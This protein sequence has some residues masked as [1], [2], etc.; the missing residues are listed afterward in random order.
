MSE[1]DINVQPAEQEVSKATKEENFTA[2]EILE[3][4]KKE[5]ETKFKSEIAGLNRKNSELASLLKKKEMEDK[6]EIEQIEI[7]KKEKQNIENEI[8]ALNRARNIDKLLSEIGLP[9]EFS[10]RITG[11]TEQEIMN[12]VNN[13]KAFLD[14]LAQ[15]KAE[16]IINERMAGGK[17]SASGQGSATKI[18]SFSDFEKLSGKERAAF[19]NS[20]GKIEN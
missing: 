7:L 8:K 9:L 11:D 1:N 3:N 15:E 4:V 6:S 16:K 18:L 14:K 17:P 19:I 13:F 20:G 2:E 5:I 12:D 10:G